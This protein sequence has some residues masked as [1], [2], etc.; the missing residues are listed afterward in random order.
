VEDEEPFHHVLADNL[1]LGEGHPR[2]ADWVRRVD[3][4]PR[5]AGVDSFGETRARSDSDG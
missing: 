2:L 1:A 5:V 4:R 3:T